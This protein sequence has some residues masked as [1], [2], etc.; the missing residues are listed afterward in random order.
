MSFSHSESR[1]P[2]LN[3]LRAF[4][5]A[6]RHLS[7]T[8]AA[9]ELNV[10][11]GAVSRLV[12]QL[13]ADLGVALFHRGPRGLELSP[14]GAA[15]LPSLT[16]AFQRL[17]AATQLITR[18]ARRPD[19]LAITML[20]T[21]A[22][23]WFMPRLADFHRR[24]PQITVDVTSADRPVD[25]LTEPV[26][27]GIQYGHGDW[28]NVTAEFLMGETVILVASP[29]LL[30]SRPLK[31]PEDV[32][33]HTLLTHST[34]P[35]AWREW[36]AAT[37]LKTHKP[38]RGPAFEHFFMS[39]EAA[40]NGLGLALVPDIFVQAELAD[41]RLVEPLPNHRVQRKGGYYLLHL[42]GRE[43]ELAIKAFRDWL[44]G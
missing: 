34:R 29:A 42:P 23:R 3:A 22:M 1:L 31:R 35:E 44:F 13:E 8:R 28:P 6:G 25:F 12:K 30:K 14:A 15:Y 21:F 7:F 36:F 41:G 38:P 5:V 20:P 37:G 16:D 9:Q 43:R 19:H 17:S 10:T 18:P 26:D 11:Q 4:E 40:V 33:R 39:I 32:K 24:H 27:V 2:S